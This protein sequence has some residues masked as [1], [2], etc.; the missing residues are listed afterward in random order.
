MKSG[1]GVNFPHSALSAP[2]LTA[3]DRRDLAEGL[4]AGIDFVGLSFVRSAAHVH[5]LRRML[6]GRPE[7]RRP[8]IIAKIERS[9]ALKDLAA[10]A[11]ASDALMVARGDLGVEI[12]LAS[13]PRAQRRFS[14][15]AARSPSR[16]SWPRRCWSR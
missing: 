13:V 7:E 14:P 2:A 5:T 10:I 4:E 16:S 12:G 11:A 1:K 9:E 15:W 6:A 8:W 3:K